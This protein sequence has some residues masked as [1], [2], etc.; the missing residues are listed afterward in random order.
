VTPSRIISLLLALGLAASITGAAPASKSTAAK[1]DPNAAFWAGKPDAAQF[2]AMQRDRIAKAKVAIDRMLAVKGKHTLDNTL[3]PY[4]EASLY[5]DAAGS[6]AGLMESVHPDSA[7][8]AAAE[9]MSQEVSSYG[10]E[11]SLNRGVYDALAAIDLTGADDETKYYVTRELRDFRLA[12][13]DK[14]EA[15][16]KRIKELRDLLVIIGQDFDRN[17]R[18]N[19]RTIQVK[20]AELAG[21]PQDFIDAHKP[22][23]SGLVT[24]NINYPDYIPTMTYCKS[25]DVRRRLFVEYNNRAYPKNVDVLKDMLAKR[26]ELA[27]LCG[28]PDWAD[29]ITANK[30]S[31]SAKTVREFIDRIVAASGPAQDRDFR[32]L[33]ARKKKDVPTATAIDAWE[34]TYWQDMVKRSD[35]GFDA[36][37]LRPYLPFAQVQQGILDVTSKMFGVTYKKVDVPVWHPSVDAYEVF[38][39]SKRIG[40]F[41][42]DMH[43]RPNK[44]NHAAQFDIRTGVEGKQIPE[45]ALICNLPGGEPGDPGLCEIDDVDTFFHEFGHLL[46]ATFAGHRR[47]LGTSGIRTEHDFVE[48]PSQMLE[49]WMKDP[50]TLQTFAKHYQTGQPVPTELVNKMRRAQD[51]AKGLQVRRQM[52]YAELSLSIDD[53]DPAQVDIDAM[54]KELVSRYQ[55]FKYVDGTH[56]SCSF[57]HLDGYS[58]VYYTYM[59]SLVIAKDMFSAFNPNDLLDPTIATRYRATVLAAGGSAPAAKLVENFLGRPFSFEAYQRWLNEVN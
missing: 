47:W 18:E 41:Y 35:Y 19:V 36:Q 30:M 20:P 38:E 14:D 46:H 22:D 23:A 50:K 29:Y 5:L 55:P 51:F 11:I 57:G 34:N 9:T 54:M 37:S 27:K 10:T 15:T 39:G 24:L 8:R 17:I 42:L 6:Q 59:W 3:A 45:A 44:Y 31:G 43:P 4:D 58:A 52:V 28:Y 16:R 56:F 12:G 1:T 32:T 2:M 40:R 25:D 33:L 49:E 21:L 13:V 26:Y 7:L 48:A 53:R